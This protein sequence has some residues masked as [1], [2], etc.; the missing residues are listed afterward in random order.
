[1]SGLSLMGC[2]F[3]LTGDYAVDRVEHFIDRAHVVE[4]APDCTPAGETG[5]VF[6]EVWTQ[7]HDGCGLG[8]E[9]DCR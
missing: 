3:R 2:S 1:M 5:H 9:L 4:L 6:Q 7:D 8:G